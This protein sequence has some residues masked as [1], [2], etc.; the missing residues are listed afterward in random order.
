MEIGD[1]DGDLG[2]QVYPFADERYGMWWIYGDITLFLLLLHRKPCY[3]L[4][5]L[6]SP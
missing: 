2:D 4:D 6:F 1:G 5:I 3:Y